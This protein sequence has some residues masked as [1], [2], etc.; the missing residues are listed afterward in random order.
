MTFFM[1]LVSLVTI[2]GTTK[3]SYSSASLYF[4]GMEKRF[5]TWQTLRIYQLLGFIIENKTN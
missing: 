1:W 5:S 4:I 3:E 2:E